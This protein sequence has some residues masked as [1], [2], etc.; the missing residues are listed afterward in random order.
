MDLLATAGIVIATALAGL[1]V[2]TLFLARRAERRAPRLGRT[3]VVDGVPLHYTDAGE[4][5]PVVFLHGA[6]GSVYDAALSVGPALARAHRSIAFDRP[7]AGYSGR[8]GADS[9]SPHVQAALL[10]LALRELGV[11]R[12]VVVGHSAGAPV[13]L[14]LALA[15]PGDVAAVVTLGGYVFSARDPSRVP[16]R[17]LTLPVVGTLLRWTV[18]V[19]LGSLLARAVVHHIFFPDPSDPAYARMAAGL[20][21]RP[22][23]LAG[24]A[25]DL[26]AI[27]AGLRDLAGRY[28]G[29]ETPVVAVHGLA[30]YVVSAGQAVRLCQLV[31]RCDLVLLEET[32]H[33]PHFTRPDAVLEAVALAWDRAHESRGTRETDATSSGRDEADT[34]APPS[35]P[36]Y[37]PA[38]VALGGEPAVPCTRNPL[39]RG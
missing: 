20:A 19:P 29:L 6:K 13:A 9:G 21:L 11:A 16:N 18:V 34:F 2:A 36:A 24:D 37:T 33:M 23:S 30:D 12:A 22:G 14:A 4:G 1:A 5:P 31:P 35:P 28:A 17:L 7:G 3:I 10:H 8:A 25:R 26:P 27:E 38:L 15:H 32:G 39:Q